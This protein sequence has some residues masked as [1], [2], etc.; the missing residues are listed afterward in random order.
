M[1]IKNKIN[2]IKKHYKSY[3]N[4][5][6]VLIKMLPHYSETTINDLYKEI[7]INSFVK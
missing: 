6:H 4:T 2:F 3:N 1:N 5:K 7:I